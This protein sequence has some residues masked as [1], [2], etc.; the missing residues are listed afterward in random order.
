[1]QEWEVRRLAEAHCCY[2]NPLIHICDYIFLSV[3]CFGGI[4]AAT[5]MVW[6]FLGRWDPL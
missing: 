3:M 2:S 4:S 1:M 6:S 5:S